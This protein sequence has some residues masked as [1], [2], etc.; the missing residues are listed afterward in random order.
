MYMS[1]TTP[2]HTW[3]RRRPGVSDKQVPVELLSG[4]GIK[5]ALAEVERTSGAT[6]GPGTETA[7]S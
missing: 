5:R 2:A 4:G 6:G 3:S 1:E 7:L